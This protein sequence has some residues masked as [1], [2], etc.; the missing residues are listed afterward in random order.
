M[1]VQH[2]NLPLAGGQV[3]LRGVPLYV[4]R[5]P[6]CGNTQLSSSVKELANRIEALVQETFP[7]QS[8]SSPES[9]AQ[10]VWEKLIAQQ[11]PSLEPALVR[12][13]RSS[14]GEKESEE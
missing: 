14:Y 4:C 10:P 5:T 12:E 11:T 9:P 1:D 3:I 2:I 8:I 13:D 7:V 6:G